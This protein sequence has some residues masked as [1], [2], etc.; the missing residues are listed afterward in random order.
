MRI[1]AANPNARV[2]HD[3]S[4]NTGCRWILMFN[5]GDP[6]ESDRESKQACGNNNNNENDI[7]NDSNNERAER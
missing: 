3:R 2:T 1:D 5:R 4:R 6:R 7:N